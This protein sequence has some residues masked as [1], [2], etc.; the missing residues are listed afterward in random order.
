MG[1][2]LVTSTFAASYAVD[3][4]AHLLAALGWDTGISFEWQDQL[5]I[6]LPNH[7]Y[8][9]VDRH[10]EMHAS[11]VRPSDAQSGDPDYS[12]V[13]RLAGILADGADQNLV[14]S[15]IPM[16][17]FLY[18]EGGHLP[19]SLMREIRGALRGAMGCSCVSRPKYES[20]TDASEGYG[21]R[22]SQESVP[23]H[24]TRLQTQLGFTIVR[25]Y[26]GHSMRSI[27][28]VAVDCDNTLWR[29]VCAEDGADGVV[30]S[31]SCLAL[32]QM[33]SQQAETGRLVCLVSKNR[34]EDVLEVFRRRTDMVLSPDKITAIRINWS[35]KSENLRSLSRQLNVGLD[36]FV[37][38]D[39]NHV[40]C[41]EVR[42]E[43]PEVQTL[44]MP[45]DEVEAFRFLANIWAFDQPEE[46][47]RFDAKRTAFYK[48]N[49]KREQL[50]SGA[51]SLSQF[52]RELDLV[53]RVRHAGSDDVARI[54]QLSQRTN[55]FSTTVVRRVADEVHKLLADP[56]TAVHV[57]DVADKFGDYG[58]VGVIV[59]KAGQYCWHCRSFMLSCRALGRGVEHRM[60]ASLA[61]E[62]LS[63][64]AGTIVVESV[65]T[66]RNTPARNFLDSCRPAEKSKNT[67]GVTEYLYSARALST[68][69]YEQCLAEQEKSATVEAQDSVPLSSSAAEDHT[70]SREAHI[71]RTRMLE[72][73]AMELNTPERLMAEVRK[74]YF[75]PRSDIPSAV[76]TFVP[77]ETEVEVVLAGVWADVLY[78]DN[79]GKHDRFT[80]LG[81]DSM[82][83]A[84]A[85]EQ[86]SDR[87]GHEFDLTEFLSNTLEELANAVP[88]QPDVGGP[89]KMSTV[90]YDTSEEFLGSRSGNLF[91]KTFIPNSGKN[92]HVEVVICKA[93]GQEAIRS[94]WVLT[95]LGERLASVGM[96]VTTFDYYGTGDSEGD[97]AEVSLAVWKSD[98]RWMLGKRRREAPQNRLCIV[99]LRLGANIS[100]EVLLDECLDARL[101]L[102]N[103]IKDGG[104]H[105]SELQEQHR[106]TLESGLV[107][108]KGNILGEV[109]GF[110]LSATLREEIRETRIHNDERPPGSTLI[111]DTEGDSALDDVARAIGA[112]LVRPES[113]PIWRKE[114]K[115]NPYPIMALDAIG[116]WIQKCAHS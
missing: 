6:A 96:A 16:Y 5:A 46:S 78:T 101:I 76:A 56:G 62:A 26:F 44:T 58:T 11:V 51:T 111:V 45:Q 80:D 89:P 108:C 99:G 55:Q 82:K 91:T 19:Q 17:V 54:A 86:L 70:Q 73:I 31:E 40:E 23:A 68:L 109:I 79:P 59:T 110:P 57:A 52:L 75:R 30:L 8:R 20:A 10:I 102:W 87:L 81:G 4:A 106:S 50:R 49:A 88:H 93:F 21:H 72:R 84:L 115:E 3:T 22:T 32:Q 33:L 43:L 112:H 90:R 48:T 66:D 94:H 7:R 107:K 104:S 34:E 105:I 103:P 28:A 77:P 114:E 24:E 92:Q 2:I 13:L 61:T 42:A 113:A 39:D 36:S 83:A 38:I 15:G 71:A 41:A 74:H 63:Q 25:R 64:G 85:V 69:S 97:C 100:Q 67:V 18:S 95:L 14:R 98:L 12:S 60:L 1:N 37:F 47:T 65:E 27:K 53:I 35:S 9:M 116:E 29:G